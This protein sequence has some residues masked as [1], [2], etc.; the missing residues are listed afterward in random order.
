VETSYR[1]KVI[2]RTRC[3]TLLWVYT[4]VSL[5]EVYC[6]DAYV[7]QETAAKAGLRRTPNNLPYL[8]QTY[9]IDKDFVVKLNIAICNVE[10]YHKRRLLN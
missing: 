6:E 9:Q 8:L 2:S 10:L 4:K 7:A 5:R 1:H 3:L